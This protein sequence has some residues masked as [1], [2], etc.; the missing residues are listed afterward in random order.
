[1]NLYAAV[2]CALVAAV[3]GAEGTPAP[4]WE[5]REA[6]PSACLP[7]VLVPEGGRCLFDD[8]C[9]TGYCCPYL[10]SCLMTTLQY[11]KVSAM[12]DD[13]RL[14]LIWGE[15]GARANTGGMTHDTS[16]AG[17]TDICNRVNAASQ[18][19][20]RCNPY[21][22]SVTGPPTI[23]LQDSGSFIKAFDLTNPQCECDARFQAAVLAD[24]WTGIFI[25]GEFRN[26][27]SD[28]GFTF[29]PSDEGAANCPSGWTR[30]VDVGECVNAT[31]YLGYGDA[32][33]YMDGHLGPSARPGCAVNSA[34]NMV[35]FNKDNSDL[36]DVTPAGTEKYLCKRATAMGSPPSNASNETTT[37][38]PPRCR[39]WTQADKD[40]F[41]RA[42]WV[43]VECPES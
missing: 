43:A 40:R 17:G 35:A 13:L 8:Q 23:A 39:A 25:N 5:S 33:D 18:D 7:K 29:L 31:A 3:G 6:I 42:G 14:A 16:A 1:M 20:G 11:T 9:A 24:S 37:P 30:I 27:C 22:T 2:A 21:M 36:G 38:R 15:G 26:H 41:A 19:F 28:D 4:P 34:N 12:G 10:R 32:T